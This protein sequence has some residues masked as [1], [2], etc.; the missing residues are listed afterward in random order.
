[1]SGFKD[2]SETAA[3]NAS[4]GAVNWVEGQNPS[5]VNNSARETIAVITTGVS[6]AE[7]SLASSTT[8]DLGPLD[9]NNIKV[10]GT[11]QI[12]QFGVVRAG[13]QKNLR[14]TGALTV[15]HSAG[16]ITTNTGANLSTLDGDH[17]TV[18]SD[19]GGAWRVL[20]HTK[21]KATISSI[22][23]LINFPGQA[24]FLAFNTVTD[25]DVTGNGTAATVDFNSEVYD[26]NSDFSGDTFTAPIVGRYQLNAN[27]RIEGTVS[28]TLITFRMITSNRTYQTNIST[29]PDSQ[30]STTVS[31][32][33]D[34]DASDTAHVTVQVDG[35]AGDTAD[36]TG[37]TTIAITSFSGCL[38]A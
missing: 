6:G 14:F 34:M 11:T 20:H 9:S 22:G 37:S 15:K 4:V 13:L 38:L 17:M 3:S 24:A 18:V 16:S 19:G 7:A 26:Q 30:T 12:D 25:A 33:A 21:S 8:S 31:A 29:P 28:A 23:G 32:V 1:M 27:V 2:F 10:T 35:M 5:T 36:I